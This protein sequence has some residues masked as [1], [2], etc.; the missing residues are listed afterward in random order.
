M[1]VAAAS[2]CVCVCVCLYLPGVCEGVSER[3]GACVL[4]VVCLVMSV[5]GV[6]VAVLS[7]GVCGCVSG[8]VWLWQLCVYASE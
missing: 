6:C 7:W 3:G 2:D 4:L 8:R 1:Y 5:T